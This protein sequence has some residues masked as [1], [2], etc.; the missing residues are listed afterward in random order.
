MT[1]FSI[2]SDN[3]IAVHASAKDAKNTPDAELFTSAKELGWLADG[4]HGS[5]LVEIWNTL[6]GQKPVSKFTSRKTAVGRIWSAIQHLSPGV[7]ADEAPVAPKKATAGKR[8]GR[9]EKAPTARDV[10]KTAKILNLLR[11]SGG[12]TLKELM[13]TTGWQPHS[14]RGFLSILGK[15]KGLAVESTKPPEGERTY[16]IKA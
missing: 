5:R 9:A 6:P 12:T 2:N 3:N 7:G 15:K 16:S 8:A 13:K 4:W 11:R 10:S 1:T 14:V